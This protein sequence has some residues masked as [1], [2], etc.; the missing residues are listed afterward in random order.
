MILRVHSLW[1]FACLPGLNGMYFRGKPCVAVTAL[2]QRLDSVAQTTARQSRP[3]Y[4]RT[5]WRKQ[6]SGML[7]RA[8]CRRTLSCSHREKVKCQLMLIA[9][10]DGS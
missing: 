10:S 3:P 6:V 1:L 9:R 8:N 2:T 5:E 7:I 4:A